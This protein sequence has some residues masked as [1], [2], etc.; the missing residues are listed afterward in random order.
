MHL[1]APVDT[2]EDGSDWLLGAGECAA[3]TAAVPSV[4]VACTTLAPLA[5]SLAHQAPALSIVIPLGIDPEPSEH[6][7]SYGKVFKALRGE[8]QDVAVKQLLH[9]GDGQLESFMEVTQASPQLSATHA[10]AAPVAESQGFSQ[11]FKLCES[12]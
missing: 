3:A 6:A 4:C 5:C 7:G 10:P 12:Q 8:V 11:P 9:A 2:Q 1:I